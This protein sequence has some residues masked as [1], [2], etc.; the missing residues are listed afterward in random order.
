MEYP[1]LPYDKDLRRKLLENDI[2]SIQEKY[3]KGFPMERL[4]KEYRVTYHTIHYWVDAEYK[5]RVHERNNKRKAEWFN[6]LS[7]EE[8]SRWNE[9]RKR[10]R[11]NAMERFPPQRKYETQ[12]HMEMESRKIWEKK[13]PEKCKEYHRISYNKHHDH[14]LKK[15]KEW[16]EKNPDYFKE[17]YQKNREKEIADK[18]EWYKKFGKDYYRQHAEQI[19][20]NHRNWYHTH[21]ERARE[22]YRR[23][24]AQPEIKARMREHYH[25]LEYKAQNKERMRQ[26][27]LK[28]KAKADLLLPTLKGRVSE[29]AS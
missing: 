2:E 25:T 21:L 1:R 10:L 4:A 14:Y 27:R 23:Y 24:R 5:N 26:W 20:T 8:R 11:K 22:T 6:T 3:A 16:R 9:N 19:R 18:R 12:R 15:H 7:S 28:K 13:H 29:G 17:Y